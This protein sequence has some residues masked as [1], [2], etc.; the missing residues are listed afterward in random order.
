MSQRFLFYFLIT[1]CL[2]LAAAARG[3]QTVDLEP[4]RY[5]VAIRLDLPNIEGAAAA[6]LVTL[7]LPPTNDSDHLV[8]LPL[9]E[10][11]P[12][13]RCPV[14]NVHHD[15]GALT[16]NIVCPGGNA[17]MAAAS[18]VLTPTT[19]EGRITMKLGGKNMTMTER[20]S[21]RRTGP[22]AP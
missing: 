12:L 9:S 2:A 20:Q 22:C 6:R 16:F 15:G 8:L 3:E 10:N 18:Y 13:S 21:G 1:G 4:G 5:E 14:L 17:A 19:F 7:C 11:N